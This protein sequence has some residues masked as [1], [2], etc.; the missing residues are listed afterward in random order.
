M[1]HRHRIALVGAAAA[2]LVAPSA[3]A[4]QATPTPTPAPSRAPT[5]ITPGLEKFSLPPSGAQTQPAPA[6]TVAS[7]MPTPAPSPRVTPT[8]APAAAQPAQRTAPPPAVRAVPTPVPQAT[9]T[10]APVAQPS[11]VP[12]APVVVETAAP[13]PSA[14]P[15]GGL[16]WR[17]ILLGLIAAGAIGVAG[18]LVGRRRSAAREVEIEA[19]PVRRPAPPLPSPAPPAAPLAPRPVTAAVPAAPAEPIAIEFFPLHIEIGEQGAVLDF[20]MGL[21]NL[22]GGAADGLRVSLLMASANPDQDAMIASFHAASTLPAAGPPVDLPA[23]EGGRIP[24]KLAIEADRIHIVPVGGR[25]MFVPLVLIDLRWRGGLSIR[26]HGAAFMVGT[27]GQ[28]AGG[29]AGKLG[30]IWLDRGAQ[31]QAGLA[32]SR[33]LPQARPVAA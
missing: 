32:A 7:P 12:T 5:I 28:G 19:P 13:A 17:W 29:Q 6:P 25:P 24:G 30:P 21:L 20:E 11:P 23:G 18:W 10:P 2:T 16:P 1:H 27:S 33:Y 31:R 22:S 14:P 26:R 3:R 8:P 9:P 4:Q 15:E